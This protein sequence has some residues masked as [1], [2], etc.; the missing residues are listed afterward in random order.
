MLKKKF[1][2]ALAV[3]AGV[4]TGLVI[5][6][7]LDEKPTEPTNL[8]PRLRLQGVWSSAPRW[9]TNPPP[10]WRS[11]TGILSPAICFEDL[12]KEEG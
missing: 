8:L 2:T 9:R 3:A 1:L 12:A 5:A 6:K 11:R 4:V 7:K 10:R